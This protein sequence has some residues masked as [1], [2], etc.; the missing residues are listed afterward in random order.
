MIS[1]PD[2][3]VL[4]SLLAEGHTHHHAA[5]TWFEG[6]DRDSIAICRVTQ[7]GLLRLLTNP[8]ILPSG[9]LPVDRAWDVANTFLA[10]KRVFFDYDP[11]GVDAAWIDMMRNP[12]A[13][14]N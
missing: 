3:N 11:P 2:V 6:C 7:M 8:K 5:W 1:L 9:A 13:G 12:A 10:D 4:L 14:P